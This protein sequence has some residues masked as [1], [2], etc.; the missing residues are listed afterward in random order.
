[1]ASS[2][3]GG[4]APLLVIVVALILGE[5]LYRRFS[6]GVR[7]WGDLG[8]FFYALFGVL[9]FSLLVFSGGAA[10][11]LAGV[12]LIGYIALVRTKFSD[13]RDGDVRKRLNG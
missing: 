4:L 7:L 13:V 9:V 2:G 1:M 6:G 8:Q 11:I 5:L 12:F 10:M 3:L